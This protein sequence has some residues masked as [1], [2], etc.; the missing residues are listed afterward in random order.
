MC[1]LRFASAALPAS[2]TIDV[3]AS[4][5]SPAP[6]P[7]ARRG[8]WKDCLF[9]RATLG[10]AVFVLLL[11]FAILL[12][13]VIAAVPAL[14]KFG[15]GFFITNVWNP[16][17]KQFGASAPIYGTLVTS[18]IALLIAVPCRSASRCS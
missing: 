5:A 8:A 2:F 14:E 12:S 17:T 4:S 18:A 6:P 15:L 16:V 11:L 3:S 10:F 9:E 13:L 7:R 1:R